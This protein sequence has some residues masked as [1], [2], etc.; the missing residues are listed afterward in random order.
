MSNK[1]KR[2]V[3]PSNPNLHHIAL[4]LPLDLYAWVAGEAAKDH[5][6]VATWITL[7]LLREQTPVVEAQNI[8]D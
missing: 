5:R 3:A 7:L 6:A 1:K 4:R 2:R 8:D